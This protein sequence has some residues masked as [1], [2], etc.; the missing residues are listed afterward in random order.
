MRHARNREVL[1]CGKSD[2]SAIVLGAGERAG[3]LP[4]VPNYRGV[5]ARLAF[6]AS[7][8]LFFLPAGLLAGQGPALLNPSR[9]FTVSISEMFTFLFL[10]LGPIKILGPFVQLTRKGDEAFARRL[11]IRAFLYSCAALLFAAFIGERSMRKY[12]ISVPVL[13]IAAGIILFLVALQ[14]VMQQF[15]TSGAAGRHEYEPS[16]RLA[17]SPL[18][19]PTIVTPY[20]VAAVIVLMTLTPDFVTRG[21]IFAALLGLMLLNLVA[22]LFAKQVLKYAGMPMQLL[23]TVL[24]IIQVA[25]GLQIILAGLRGLGLLSAG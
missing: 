1:A 3:S 19:F 14:T 6:A 16:M 24:G 11:A 5:L 21:E 13:A 22:M 18:A 9:A 23:G 25:L 15:D 8:S 20:G 12:H 4:F 2:E 7:L 10:M 17:V